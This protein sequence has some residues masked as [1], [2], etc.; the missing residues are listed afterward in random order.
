MASIYLNHWLRQQSGLEE[1]QETVQQILP[2]LPKDVTV[3][4]SQ[5]EH[6][7]DTLMHLG[8]GSQLVVQ[9]D[10]ALK[11]LKQDKGQSNGTAHDL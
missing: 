11:G 10:R 3:A 2:A 9:R 7:L 1:C 6:G 4:V 5:G 8:V